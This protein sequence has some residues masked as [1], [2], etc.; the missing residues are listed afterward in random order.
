MPGT[1]TIDRK[2][3]AALKKSIEHWERLASGQTRRGEW[4]GVAQC[5]L[6]KLF[7]D[8]GCKG[9]PVAERTGYNYC[10]T[11]PYEIVQAY[12]DARFLRNRKAIL[13]S[14]GFQS[15]ARKELRFLKSLLPKPKQKQRS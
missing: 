14:K 10:H 4:I 5:S 3:L 15:A 7:W 12:V 8:G 6:C 13:N 1:M 2:T 11:T 9:C